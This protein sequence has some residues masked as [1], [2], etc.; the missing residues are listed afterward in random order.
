MNLADCNSFLTT[1]LITVNG[2]DNLI[3]LALRTICLRYIFIQLSKQF[4]AAPAFLPLPP[5][6]RR[7]PSR[8][9][10]RDFS[11]DI[12]RSWFSGT[13]E[14]FVAVTTNSKKEEETSCFEAST[15]GRVGN[16]TDVLDHSTMLPPPQK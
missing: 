1:L 16:V 9:P 12:P 13:S 5:Y 4:F 8:D 11:H 10:P 15:L 3:R 14:S 7:R 6:L 2:V